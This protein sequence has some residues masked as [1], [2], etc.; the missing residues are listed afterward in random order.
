MTF[1]DMPLDTSK[2]PKTFGHAASA[3]AS[4]DDGCDHDAA[5]DGEYGDIS[6]EEE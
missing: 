1:Q 5:E 3:T 2:D 6:E 4:Q